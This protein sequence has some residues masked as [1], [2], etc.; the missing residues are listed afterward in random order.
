MEK[1]RTKPKQTKK[2]SRGLILLY[3]KLKLSKY[4]NIDG[5]PYTY[6]HLIKDRGTIDCDK[7][8]CIQ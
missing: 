2:I 6:S 8:C 5:D 3:I 7:G 4:C 1:Q